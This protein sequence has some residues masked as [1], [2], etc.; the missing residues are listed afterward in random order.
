LATE[1]ILESK[2]RE[3]PRSEP[4]P[5]VLNESTVMKFQKNCK[6]SE[7]RFGEEIALR[8]GCVEIIKKLMIDLLGK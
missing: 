1:E 2:T 6:A 7:L 8:R 5:I 3:P 4:M